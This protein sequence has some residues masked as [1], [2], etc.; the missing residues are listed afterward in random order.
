MQMGHKGKGGETFAYSLRLNVGIE[1]KRDREPSAN[2]NAISSSE[3][4]R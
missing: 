1:M 4:M 3:K 2:E